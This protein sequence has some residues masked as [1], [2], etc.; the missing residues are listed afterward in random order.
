MNQF[1]L[2][3]RAVAALRGLAV[4]DAMG[5]ATEGYRPE[6]VEEIYEAQIRELVDPVNL[7]PELG[8]DR[9]RGAVGPVTR[10][11]VQV[12]AALSGESEER[13]DPEDLGW[14]VALGITVEGGEIP[15]LVS[16]ARRFAEGE[17]LAAGCAVAAAVAAGVMGVMPRDV[18]SQ[19]ALAADYAGGPEL[20]NAVLRAAGVAQASGGRAPGEVLA[21]QFSPAHDLTSAVAFVFGVAFAT[22]SVRRGVP[23]TINLGGHASLTGGLVGAICGAF[24]PNT[25]VD[26]WSSEV[27][28][29]SGL[30][31]EALAGRLLALR[32][33]PSPPPPPEEPRRGR[34]S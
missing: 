1:E 24:A 14:A 5:A 3:R 30:A 2:Q 17:A 20:A 32:P 25:A 18:L 6:E 31:L 4:G 9:E 22:Q 27:E 23:Q 10:A 21:E 33:P 34:R 11:A 16:G 8:P 12:A 7:Y 26:A 29:S 28:A 15:A 19:A 13:P